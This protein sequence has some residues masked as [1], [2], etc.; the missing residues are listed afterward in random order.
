MIYLLI[1]VGLAV[2]TC[3]AAR[4]VGFDRDRS[5]YPMMLILIASGYV[6][7]ALRDGSSSIMIAEAGGFAAFLLLAV[8]AF[9]VDLW[10]AVA[11]LAAHGVFDLVHGRI[12]ADPGVPV[13]W[14]AFCGSYD[15]VAAGFLA[16]LL[17]RK[18]LAGC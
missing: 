18:P 12:I 6:L 10:I 9:R 13:W 11:G 17:R 1:G 7:F 2:V 16:W 3:A 14:P 4:I 5:F 8:L 15:I